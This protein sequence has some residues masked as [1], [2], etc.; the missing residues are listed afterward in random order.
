MVID[1]E[2]LTRAFPEGNGAIE[3][4]AIYEIRDGRIAKAWFISGPKTIPA[5]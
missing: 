5:S 3:L 2:V 4:I 1:H